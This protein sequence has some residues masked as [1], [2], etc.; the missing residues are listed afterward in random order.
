MLKLPL[1]H[2]ICLFALGDIAIYTDITRNLAFFVSVHQRRH[3]NWKPRAVFSLLGC[4][5]MPSSCFGE[6]L[7]HFL[8]VHLGPLGA[9]DLH[10]ISSEDFPR[11]PTVK[12]LGS[13]AP[14][15]QPVQGIRGDDGILYALE[16]D[17]LM[18]DLLF[19]LLER[20]DLLSVHPGNDERVHLAASNGA[21]YFSCFFKLR[22]QVAVFSDK[23]FLCLPYGFLGH[24][25]SR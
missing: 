14:Y 8:G 13:R 15:R 9:D 20:K 7:R 25:F 5:S 11:F 22:A 23:L 3:F 16:H 19:C 4:F 24:C 21:Q 12:R 10:S 17:S 6:R 1:Y 18:T 2:F